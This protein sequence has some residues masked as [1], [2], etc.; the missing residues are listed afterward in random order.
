MIGPGDSSRSTE[1]FSSRPVPAWRPIP[2]Y[3]RYRA[4][5][6]GRI[7]SL[8]NG[9]WTNLKPWYGGYENRRPKVTLCVNKTKKHFF[10]HTLVCLAYHG[11]R[12]VGLLIL[13]DDDDPENN[14]PT[15]LSYGDDA[16]NTRDAERNGRRPYR[17]I[18]NREP[19]L[20]D[21]F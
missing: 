1:A 4:T 3:P 15:N 19:E 14:R 7:Q 6:H 8:R 5:A 10:V 16:Q 17:I 2:G 9:R 11:P 20:I 12:P 21:A 13:H 18:N